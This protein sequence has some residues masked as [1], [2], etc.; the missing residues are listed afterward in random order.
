MS[1]TPIRRS[2]WWHPP[3]QIF[4]F[5]AAVASN[6]LPTQIAVSG[7]VAKLSIQLSGGDAILK[8]NRFVSL[9]VD[10]AETTDTLKKGPRQ[11]D[12]A[13]SATRSEPAADRRDRARAKIGTGETRP[14]NSRSLTPPASITRPTALG[15]W[16]KTAT[17][18]NSSPAIPPTIRCRPITAQE[19][20]IV[21]LWFCFGVPPNVE[22]KQFVMGTVVLADL[23]GIKAAAD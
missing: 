3:N 17:T 6:K 19:G 12:G 22:I 21:K 8:A 14:N 15:P 16:F 2:R 18:P 23:N 9:N 11:I 13:D 5:V 1:C 20:K 10:V 7:D 4:I